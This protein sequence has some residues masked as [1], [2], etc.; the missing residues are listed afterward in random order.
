MIE[1]KPH[2]QEVS[3]AILKGKNYFKYSNLNDDY[4]QVIEKINSIKSNYQCIVPLPF[5]H[6]GT[7]NFGKMFSDNML[8]SSMVI[9]HWTNVPLLSN[10]AA[11]APILEGKNIMQF[12]SPAF[13]HKEIEK[14]LPNKKSFLVLINKEE[15]NFREQEWLNISKTIFTNNSFE[16]RELT[17]DDVFK[18]NSEQLSNEFALIKDSL[19]SYSNFLCSEKPDTILYNSF[20]DSKSENLY[21]GKGAF[22]GVKKDFNVLLTKAN[23]NLKNDRDYIVSFWYYNKDELRLQNTCIIEECDTEGN[24]CEWNTMWNPG[25][26]MVIDGDWSLVEKKFRVK[27]NDEQISIF[28]NG[29]S[30]STQEIYVDDLMIRPADVDVYKIGN[31][32][33]SVWKNTLYTSKR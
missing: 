32:R 28:L 21:R 11:R 2:H 20:D 17:Y 14:D 23:Y 26:S 24:N 12:F 27:N 5:Y 3:E 31:N 1:A 22:K 13:I 10:S 29:D 4:K 15:L 33:N 19:H 8:R 18:N 30:K 16:L 9:S 25:E 6:I 7:E